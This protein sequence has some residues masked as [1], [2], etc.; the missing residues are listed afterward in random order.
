MLSRMILSKRNRKVGRH[1]GTTEAG[2]LS[3]RL[4]RTRSGY[5]DLDP[6]ELSLGVCPLVDA[7][8]HVTLGWV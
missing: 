3:L 1:S 8:D 2:L 6:V 5:S 4:D 7:K